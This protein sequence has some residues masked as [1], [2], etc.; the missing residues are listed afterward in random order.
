MVVGC[1]NAIA[2]SVSELT[3]DGIEIP[4]LFVEEC[5]GDTAKP[6]RRHHL[7]RIA[8]APD[9]GDERPSLMGLKRERTFGNTYGKR[10]V[11]A[12]SS[13]RIAIAWRA[14]GT[15]CGDRIFMRRPGILHSDLAKSNSIH[16]AWRSS[17]A[18]QTRAVQD[19]ARTG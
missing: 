12:L 17:P 13:S 18:E 16:S 8:H 1:P 5:R 4:P 19:A 9:G 10:P 15:M 3:L 7:A 14:S 11:T 6:M 2:L